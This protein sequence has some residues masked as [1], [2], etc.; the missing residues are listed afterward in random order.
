MTTGK[1]KQPRLVLLCG[2]PASG[3]T[4]LARELAESYGAVRLNPD[5]WVQSTR[6]RSAAAAGRES[7]VRK[8]DKLLLL[9]PLSD[10]L[11]GHEPRSR[12]VGGPGNA[13]DAPGGLIVT[14][15]RSVG[16]LRA[17]ESWLTRHG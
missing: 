4:T 11:L 9:S 7:A 12:R 17:T 2:L 8:A 5:E 16:R 1:G 6:R 3:K 14:P 13:H 15:A 10:G